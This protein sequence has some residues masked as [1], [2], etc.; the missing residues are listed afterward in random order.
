MIQEKDTNFSK[1]RF[2]IV[3]DACGS[4][5]FGGHMKG[6][7]PHAIDLQEIALQLLGRRF[8]PFGAR[9]IFRG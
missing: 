3:H 9:P 6:R 4:G 7:G 2:C 5:A 8:F 1:S